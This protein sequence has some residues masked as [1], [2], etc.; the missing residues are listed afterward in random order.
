MYNIPLGYSLFVQTPG[1]DI[2]TRLTILCVVTMVFCI[3]SFGFV[4]GEED[5][6]G[7]NEV[8]IAVSSQ[9]EK[10]AFEVHFETESALSIATGDGV[11]PMTFTVE[12]ENFSG[13]VRPKGN[14]PIRGAVTQEGPDAS[15]TS[16]TRTRIVKKGADITLSEGD[17]Q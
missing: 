12:A 17:S 16:S 9:V 5:S 13:V 2:M 15:R 11:T 3:A 7:A 8:E 1:V 4:L 14:A 6:N 10:T